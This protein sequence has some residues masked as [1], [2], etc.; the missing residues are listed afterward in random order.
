MTTLVDRLR[1]GAL[2]SR[3]QARRVRLVGVARP[4]DRRGA[5]EAAQ[6]AQGR[7]G[8]GARDR[9]RRVALLG[10]L[11]HRRTRAARLRLR[12]RVGPLPRR[13]RGHRARRCRR[14][15]RRPTTSTSRRTAARSRSPP[16]SPTS[17]A[18]CTGPTSSRSTSTTKRK[19]VLTPSTGRSDSAPRYSPDGRVVA[20]LSHDT[21]RSHVDQGHLEIVPRRGGSAARARAR[22][23]TA[24]RSHAQWARDGRGILFT[25]ED[26][27]R[28]GLW[29]LAP[30]RGARR[31]S[32]P[33]RRHGRRLRA[34]AR[35]RDDRVRPREREPSARALRL[36][37]R[38]R[39]RAQARRDERR[40]PRASRARRDAR[41]HGE[42][43]GRRA[44]AGVGHLSAE[45]RS[46]AEV[47]AAALDP[48][49]PARRAR[50]RLAL[51]LERARVRRA[52]LRRRDGQLP[53]L[54]GLRAALH[55]DHRRELRRE[56]VRR[57][58][59]DDRRAAAR[60]GPSTASGWSRPAEA[61]AASWS[62]T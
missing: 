15:S 39:R 23:S 40:A 54:V 59:G 61:T 2:V 35:R 42:R 58:R 14:G 19:R 20:Y 12:R 17:R 62:R 45:L 55:R 43:V 33:R 18:C 41:D 27:G 48:R 38:R 53:R 10:P 13:A 56:G 30:G 7:Q 52:R 1:V 51:P 44:G 22:R 36:R 34:V 31:R 32:S 6:G 4:G 11:A 47:A 24:R 8:Q 50:R 21:E 5:G 28:T 29:R 26:R 49:R 3:R 57:H 60:P 9:A 46:E 37:G 25:A 16:T